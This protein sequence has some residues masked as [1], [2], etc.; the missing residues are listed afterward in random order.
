MT[1]D[2]LGDTTLFY[3]YSDEAIS[4]QR[5]DHK[6]MRPSVLS[7]IPKV[8]DFLEDRGRPTFRRA[9]QASLAFDSGFHPRDITDALSGLSKGLYPQYTALVLTPM[10]VP[11]Q[12]KPCHL[13]SYKGVPTH[14]ELKR[15]AELNALKSAV[16]ANDD[17]KRAGEQYVRSIV[18][19]AGYRGV[20]QRD[21]LGLVR[22]KNGNNALD[23]AAT[24]PCTGKQFGISVKN[25]VEWLHA[26]SVAGDRT[27]KDCYTKAEAHG[28]APWLFVPYATPEAVL[29]CRYNGIRL[30]VIGRQIVPAEDSQKR[31][32]RDLIKHQLSEVVGPQPFEFL[33]N[34]PSRTISGSLDAQRDVDGIVNEDQK[35]R[36]KST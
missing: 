36:N 19:E 11:G 4:D 33:Y 7:V 31:R 29:R 13:Y 25:Q 8:M 15:L 22:D 12:G 18:I 17:L 9:I 27:I 32:M 3:T 6:V 1:T 2:L 16:L 28:M 14:E 21:R 34:R 35:Q 10:E 26:G 24:S 20:T 23:L 30:T 5:T